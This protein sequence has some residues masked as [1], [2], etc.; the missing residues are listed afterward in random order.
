[1]LYIS[2]VLLSWRR[3]QYKTPS[4]H[5]LIAW[6]C[7][8]CKKETKTKPNPLKSESEV[9]QLCYCLTMFLLLKK[10]KKTLRI[11]KTYV[12]L[13][14]KTQERTLGK[15]ERQLLNEKAP[16]PPQ[17]RITTE[18]PGA[19]A[20][21]PL[22]LCGPILESAK[23]GNHTLGG[24]C[25]S[26]L[27]CLVLWAG[28]HLLAFSATVKSPHEVHC[29]SMGSLEVIVSFCLIQGPLEMRG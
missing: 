4:Q 17:G 19:T 12:L 7:F 21:S 9:A 22:S 27:F 3:F 1:M 2:I 11:V 28:L 16:L 25:R 5:Y 14:G 29:K 13:T 6:S 10:K 20:L 15:N 24:S 26:R 23:G 8:F 18:L